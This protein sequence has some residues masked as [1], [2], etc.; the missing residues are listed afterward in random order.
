L[1]SLLETD[2]QDLITSR[3]LATA[4][5]QTS[6]LS[7]P[8]NGRFPDRK[9]CSP[10]K[11][12]ATYNE[13]ITKKL[14]LD[15]SY[16]ILSSMT[17]V[18]PQD[19]DDRSPRV[20]GLHLGSGCG[21]TH[22][23]L[24]APG[25]LNG[26]GIYVTYNQD[27]DLAMD[28]EK[29]QQAFLLRI[30]LRSY[31]LSNQGCA[32][33]LSSKKHS[34]WFLDCIALSLID[35]VVHKLKKYE[36]PVV[37]V[38]D[39]VRKLSN[40]GK[41]EEVVQLTASIL[42]Q[43]AVA[44]HKETR[45]P[46]FALMSSLTSISFTTVSERRVKI[47][48][49][50]KFDEGSIDFIIQDTKGEVDEKHKATILGCSGYHIRSIVHS[51]ETY[52]QVGVS[53]VQA[54][55][56]E[57]KDRMETSVSVTDRPL[58]RDYVVEACRSGASPDIQNAAIEIL[59]DS[60]GALPPAIVWLVCDELAGK[61]FENT[62]HTDAPKQLEVT[63]MHYDLFRAKYELPV[64]PTSISVG[65]AGDRAMWFKELR[66]LREYQTQSD[67]LLQKKPGKI[68]AYTGLAIYRGV[69]YYPSNDSHPSVDR[70]FVAVHK[71][72]ATKEC[73]VLVQDKINARGFP[74]AVKDLNL[75]A[76]ILKTASRP[77]LCIANVV[78][79][80]PLTTSQ[81]G[82]EHPYVLVRD[83]E[84]DSFYSVNFAPAIRFLRSRHKDP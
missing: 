64:I 17:N 79:A 63:A 83:S 37:I 9:Y 15:A 16:D 65:G 44:F 42:G 57:T 36:R 61:V 27:Q 6:R 19:Q 72:D 4:L 8:F 1:E 7:A 75:A 35:L 11:F 51:S 66:F 22:L 53:T 77:V 52:L 30:L 26:E 55:L 54:V 56:S 5:E 10:Y 34:N 62:F 67:S 76:A 21:K 82:F 3:D 49:P 81:G 24:N 74:K 68:L 69:Y 38:V 58:L 28:R 32:A 48:K 2:L 20:I 18:G 46:C 43:L 60:K 31:G 47:V 33:F 14:I 13:E 78:G 45:Q 39:E 29:P 70:A 50:P 25:W 12:R 40:N 23:L 80:G 73:L 41:H 59:V 84:V 71:D